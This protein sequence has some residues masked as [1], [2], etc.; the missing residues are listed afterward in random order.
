MCHVV[1]QVICFYYVCQLINELT[2]MDQTNKSTHRITF[3]KSLKINPHHVVR[4]GFIFL[5]FTLI[6]LY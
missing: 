1:R 6:L 4:A 3:R 5:D 2:A